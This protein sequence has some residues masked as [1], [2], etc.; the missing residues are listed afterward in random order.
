MIAS[1][2]RNGRHGHPVLLVGLIALNVCMQLASAL[3]LKLAPV[4]TWDNV[5][6]VGLILAAVLLLNVVLFVSWG[7]LHKR[8]PI[9]VTYPASAVFLPALLAMA[10]WLGEDINAQQLIGAAAVMT[11]VMLLIVEQ[12]KRHE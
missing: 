8:F 5:I 6:H 1:T 3:L 4:L 10:W 7:I 12:V 11:G 2:E 9:S